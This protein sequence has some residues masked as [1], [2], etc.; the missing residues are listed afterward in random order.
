[1]ST[2]EVKVPNIGDFDAVEIIEVLVAPGDDVQVESSLITVESDK[3]SM[4]IPSPAAGKVK[5]VA[6]KVG[7]KIAEGGLILMLE[8]SASAE[9]KVETKPAPAAASKAAEAKPAAPVETN[10][11][12][13]A[14]ASFSGT[15]D[16]QVEVVVLGSG[17][18]GYT[19]A[20][21][22]ADLGKKVILI[23][24]EPNLGGVCLNV[25]CIPSKALLHVAEVMEEAHEF[26]ALGV[27]YAHPKVDTNK[28]RDHKNKVVGK[29][30]TGLKGLAKQ[31]KVEVLHGYGRFTSAHTIEVEADGKK[32][33]VQ[34]D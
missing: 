32:Q 5:S 9:P 10:A 30:T 19:A 34:F 11:V 27:A 20:F 3:A 29:L 4:E 1:M 12:A 13:P 21:R 15:V 25:G 33:T 7:D 26:S 6:V 17:P 18:G 16:I 2:I 8:T 22:A 31:R 14:A 23:E 24:K 28:L